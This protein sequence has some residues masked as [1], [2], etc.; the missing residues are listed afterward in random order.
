MSF[1]AFGAVFSQGEYKSKY[2][3]IPIV[4]AHAHPDSARDVA[5]FLKASEVIRQKYNSNLAFWIGLNEPGEFLN[6]MT[7]ASKNRMRFCI[8]QYGPHRGLD[9]TPE[10]II[11]KVKKGYLGFKFAF[12][13]PYRWLDD[14]E[15]GI[16]R[17]DDPR[18]DSLFAPLEQAN[19]LMAGFHVADPNGPF[20]N[21]QNW[22][23]DPVYFWE[24]IRA[25]EN[26]LIKYPNLIF[27][28]A[29]SVWLVCQD[30]Q[31][32]YLRYMLSRYPNLYIDTSAIYQYMPL[33]NSDN[34]RSF[35]IEYQDRV[36]YG[37]DFTNVPD[38]AIERTADRYA[39]TFAIFET[40]QMVDG[41]FSNGPVQGLNLPREV[42]E[43]IYYKNALKLFP[44]IKEALGLK[45]DLEIKK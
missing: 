40:D 22:M 34:L 19:I 29:H 8:S 39:V 23:K 33:V 30:A 38:N 27:M 37:T 10:E 43:K 6:E 26:L 9:V 44:A 2:P 1:T 42:L 31:I 25:F 28:A 5:N 24:Q 36:L 15:E 41:R 12:P 20:G 45:C 35:Y 11:E 3:D 21:R 32:D 16:S 13:A 7:A 18:Y 4:D 14:G 17:V